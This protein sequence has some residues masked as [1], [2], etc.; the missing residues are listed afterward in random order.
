MP[1][2]SACDQFAG[3]KQAFR[4]HQ[5]RDECQHENGFAGMVLTILFRNSIAGRLDNTPADASDHTGNKHHGRRI[6]LGDRIANP[7]GAIEKGP[8]EVALKANENQGN[9]AEHEH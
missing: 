9:G 8:L 2:L 3:I 1:N 5:D 4:N 6:I 7:Q